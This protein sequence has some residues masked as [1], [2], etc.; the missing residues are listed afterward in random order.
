VRSA[1]DLLRQTWGE[2][3]DARLQQI[4]S[5]IEGE[6]RKRSRVEALLEILEASKQAIFDCLCKQL[7][8]SVVSKA[9][10]LKLLNL[11]L[12]KYHFLLRS[13]ALASRPFGLIVDP[14]NVCNLA[15]PGCLHSQRAGILP[16]ERLAAFLK[17]YGPYAIHTSFSNYGEPLANPHTP[18][19]IR[20]A[21]SYLMRTVLSTSL[22]LARFDADAYVESG[23]DSMVVSID[24]ATQ[25]VYEIFRR[26]GNLD[27]VHR[28]VRKLVEAR[29]RLCKRTPILTSIWPSSTTSTRSP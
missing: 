15:C 2:T 18:R 27:F 12:A 29:R 21:K 10:T 13:S 3:A 26:K 14:S 7:E 8:S 5:A 16:E 24:G 19:F 4:L 11:C 17:Y 1:C 25:P 28:N 6:V 22:S 20:L 23:L 9:L